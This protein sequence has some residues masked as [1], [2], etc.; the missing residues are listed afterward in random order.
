MKNMKP[1]FDMFHWYIFPGLFISTKN[2]GSIHDKNKISIKFTPTHTNMII[3]NTV[4]F[5][6]RGS[7]ICKNWN[8]AYDIYTQTLHWYYV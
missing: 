6:R 2:Q 5:P 8:A 3:N 1:N 4:S 7:S